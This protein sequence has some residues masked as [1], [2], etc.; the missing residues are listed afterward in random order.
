MKLLKVDTVNEARN[1]LADCCAGTMLQTEMR[2]LPDAAGC[3]LAENIYSKE[4]I[5]PYRRSIMDGYAVRSR[6]LGAAGD[7]IPTMLKVRGEVLLGSD[8]SDLIV[9]PGCAVYVPTGGFVPEGADAVVMVEYCE[10]FGAGML[11]VSK[12]AS[13]GENV[14]QAGEDISE[15]DMLLPKGRKLR[16]QDIGVLAA[17]GV[18]DIP[19]YVPWKVTVISTGDELVSPGQTPG[20]GQIRD[21]NTY[22]IASRSAAEGM[23][24][25]RTVSVKDDREALAIAI[26]QAKEDSDLVVMSGGSSQGKKD[27]TADL[28]D[29]AADHGVLTH[30]IAAKPGKP[31]IT[32]FDEESRTLFIGLPGH[33]AAA[34]MV[35]EQILINLWRGLICREKERTLKAKITVNV[36]S[37]PGRMTFQLVKISDGDIPE[38]APVFARSGMISPVSEADGY[39]VMSENQEGIRPGE[40]VDVFLWK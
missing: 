18:T 19:V 35:Y 6:D 40:M 26:A 13:P 39:F 27:M 2:G 24:V 31:T 37:A 14:V 8:C 3:I 11:A 21:I 15:G 32:G 30:G 12:S 36:P 5:P 10:T 38:A 17:C 22:T 25:I 33:P 9:E 28:I 34:L 1:K 16:P 4:N 20:P 7:M 23:D 29:E